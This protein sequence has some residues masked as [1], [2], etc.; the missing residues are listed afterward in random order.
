MNR[1]EFRPLLLYAASLPW[2]SGQW[3]SLVLVLVLVVVLLVLGFVLV[4][5]L[6]LVQAPSTRVFLLKRPLQNPANMHIMH[7]PP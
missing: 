1:T 2:G 3:H 6:V 4:L 5:V 7:A